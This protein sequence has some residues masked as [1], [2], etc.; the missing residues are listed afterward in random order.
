MRL[1][2]A[3]VLAASYV[4]QKTLVIQ[5]VRADRKKGPPYGAFCDLRSIAESRFVPVIS[6]CGSRL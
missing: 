3:T 5:K 6:R 2:N 4:D 1:R